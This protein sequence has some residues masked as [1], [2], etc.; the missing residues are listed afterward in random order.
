MI[1]AALLQTGA[2]YGARGKW[3]GL[4]FF[5]EENQKTFGGGKHFWWCFLLPFIKKVFL[6]DVLGVLILGFGY[7]LMFS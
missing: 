2:R 5:S 4:G 3:L 6:N 1:H 7:F